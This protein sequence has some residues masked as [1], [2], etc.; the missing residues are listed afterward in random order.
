MEL[1]SDPSGRKG[2]GR[3]ATSSVRV[4][5]YNPPQIHQ[6]R[7][8]ANMAGGQM[9]SA[10]TLAACGGLLGERVVAAS[11]P[12]AARAA[13]ALLLA[14][15]R[16]VSGAAACGCDIN[17]EVRTR[18][19]TA[20]LLALRGQYGGAQFL[21][22]FTAAE[23]VSSFMMNVSPEGRTH[24]SNRGGDSLRRCA[25]NFVLPFQPSRSQYI[26]PAPRRIRR[27][28]ICLVC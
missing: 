20:R 24:K 28:S 26:R 10:T 27:S 12:R 6:S 1:S 21:P 19:F 23:R 7:C 22:C 17:D 25:L 2:Y 5:L 9:V 8:G 4:R 18:M 15:G 3:I 16:P 11:R 13:P 14:W